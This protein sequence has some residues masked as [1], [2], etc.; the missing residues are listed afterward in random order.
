MAPLGAPM[1]RLWRPMARSWR[2]MARAWRPLAR[3]SQHPWRTMARLGVPMAPLDA[4]LAPLDAPMARPWRPMARQLHLLA[5]P[6]RHLA[7]TWRAR[8]TPWRTST[9]PCRPLARSWRARGAP[10]R[11]RGASLVRPS[12]SRAL[13]LSR[14]FRPVTVTLTPA[15]HSHAHSANSYCRIVNAMLETSTKWRAS[16]AQNHFFPG[17]Q[18]RPHKRFVNPQ[19]VGTQMN[20]GTRWT[21]K[22]HHEFVNRDVL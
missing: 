12:L 8:G 21:S 10:W 19:H 2:P 3:P 4:P 16:C 7:R 22:E 11:A 9:Y 5:R 1:A 18:I 17:L 14:S 6:W 20:E 15:R 13:R